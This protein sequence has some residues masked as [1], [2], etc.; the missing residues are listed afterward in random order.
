MRCSPAPRG[1]FPAAL[2]WPH[3]PHAPACRGAAR[4]RSRHH[5][6]PH[7]TPRAGQGVLPC[8]LPLRGRARPRPPRGVRG[9]R[10]VPGGAQ[11]VLRGR[12]QGPAGRA[13]R[14]GESPLRGHRRGV[15]LGAGGSEGPRRARAGAH[16]EQRGQ[17]PNLHGLPGAARQGPPAIR[18]RR[19]A[20]RRSRGGAAA[21]P[22][23]RPA[24]DRRKQPRH[25]RWPA[26]AVRRL[27]EAVVRPH[28]Q[29]LRRHRGARGRRHSQ[30]PFL[31]GV[32]RRPPQQI[33]AAAPR[34]LLMLPGLAGHPVAGIRAIRQPR[35]RRRAR[36]SGAGLGFSDTGRPFVWVVRPGM[37]RGRTSC[38]LELPA[39][40]AEQIGDRGMVVRWAP[41]GKVLGH[42]AVGAFLTHSGWN[43]TVEALSEGVPMACLPCFG[44]QFGTARYACDVWKVGVE[45]GRLGRA[46][47]RAAIDRLMGPG[48]EGETIRERA[49]DLKGKVGR[50]IEEGGS[51]HMALLALLERIASF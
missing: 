21:L 41:Q 43:S 37:V 1:P 32:P 20:G 4:Q 30:R 8:G 3:D 38:S 42:A 13:A 48:I 17:L 35:E 18:V 15:V 50:C 27:S 22:G 36:A 40:L 10:G 16:D 33:L 5:R 7:G 47:V 45:V 14:R 31:A 26:R 46:A 23:E 11:R 24:A 49:R 25:L 9:H 39:G 51:S 28:R 34:R 12:L 6:A 44:D 29:H 2:P 19:V